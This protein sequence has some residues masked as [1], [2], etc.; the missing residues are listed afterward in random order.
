VNH[1]L[2][3][4]GADSKF[5]RITAV[6]SIIREPRIGSNDPPKAIGVP[7]F[8][9]VDFQWS[10]D[11]MALYLIR[12]EYEKKGSEPFWNQGELW[13]YDL[14]AGHFAVGTNTL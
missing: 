8:R 14:G 6:D 1:Q 9:E 3:V 4:V 7:F 5:W 2:V 11:S 12:D 13:K 10:K